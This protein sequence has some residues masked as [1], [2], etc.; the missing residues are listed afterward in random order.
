M[1][2]ADALR[3]CRTPLLLSL[4]LLPGCAI[5][6]EM[7]RLA[8]GGW[9]PERSSAAG[10][11]HR[12]EGVGGGGDPQ[13]SWYSHPSSQD[14]RVNAAWCATVGPPAVVATPHPAFPSTP[15]DTLTVV[16]W[17]SYIEGGDLRE[18]AAKELGLS[19]GPRGPEIQEGFTPFILLIQEAHQRSPLVPI[20]PEDAPVP[21]EVGPER[22]PPDAPDILGVAESCGL[23]L[24]YVPSARNGSTSEGGIGEDKGNAVLSTFPLRDAVAIELPFESG[25][26]V[27]TG[28]S[29]DVGLPGSPLRVV[30]VHLDVASTLVRTLTTGNRTRERQVAG[31]LDAMDLHGWGAGPAVVGGDFNTWSSRDAAL[32]VMLLSHPDSPPI[33]WETSMGPFPADHLFFRADREG[34]FALV[35][36]SYR[37]IQGLYGSDHQA[38]IFRLSLK[39]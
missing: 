39:R 6:H 12:S 15:P 5:H 33:T 31:L 36:N 16:A 2:S 4:A 20:V 19:C 3:R 38:R 26:K 13:V 10:E 21:W 8:P 24:T 34:T 9:C 11:G 30:S 25:R 14:E 18:F 35:P 29:F 17:N 28:A 1:S 37:T 32:K 22:R 7:A 23:S 27:A